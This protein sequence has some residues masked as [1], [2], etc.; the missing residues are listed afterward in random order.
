MDSEKIRVLIAD[1][2]PRRVTGCDAHLFGGG[3]APGGHAVDPAPAL[4]RATSHDQPCGPGGRREYSETGR[5]P[6]SAQ[7]RFVFR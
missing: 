4:P 6:V 3:S 2:H 7:G 5:N 1:D